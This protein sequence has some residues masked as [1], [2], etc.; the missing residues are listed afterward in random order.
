MNCSA[1]GWETL[2]SKYKR[3]IK[4]RASLLDSRY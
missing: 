4:T 1:K 3:F 2:R